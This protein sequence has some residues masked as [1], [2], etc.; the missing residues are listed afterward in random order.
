MEM[1]ALRAEFVREAQE[2]LA[3]V[4]QMILALEASLRERDAPPDTWDEIL[5]I[6]HTL[7]GN[8]GMMGYVRGETIAH[9]ME[10][11]VTIARMQPRDVAQPIVAGLFESLDALRAQVTA[12]MGGSEGPAFDGRG[13][14]SHAPPSRPAGRAK[15]D[16]A[17]WEEQFRAANAQPLADVRIAAQ[18]LDRLLELVGE[19]SAHH[20]RLGNIIG[21]LAERLPSSDTSGTEARDVIDYVAKTI[22]ELRLRVTQARLLPLS[23][24]FERTSR[25]VRDVCLRAG[26]EAELRVTGGGLVVDK[27][28]VDVLREPLLHIIRNAIDH[29]LEAPDARIAVGKPRSGTIH[30][31]AATN[32]PDLVILVRDDGR[33]IAR[34]KLAAKARERGI[35]IDGWTEDELLELVFEPTLST[36]DAVTDLSGRGIGMD[37]ARRSI[38]RFGGTVDVASI[39]GVGTAFQLRVPLVVTVHRTLVVSCGDERF[40]IPVT[41]VAATFRIHPSS[42]HTA[43]GQ[44]FTRFRD[45]MLPVDH[46][47]TRLG[48]SRVALPAGR[49]PQC[50][51]LEDGTRWRGVIVDAVVGQEDVVVKDLDP[52]CGRPSGIAGASV[53][54]DGSVVMVLD[55]RAIAGVRSGRA[56]R[57]HVRPD[58]A[59]RA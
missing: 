12:P 44:P 56:K 51:V 11:H 35:D 7:K 18:E 32:G 22:G 54:S 15:R 8:C 14:P 52:L 34:H 10:E 3:R 37:A 25:V 2:L 9:A 39:D 19:L 55:P 27:A 20:N 31:D 24:A 29:G 4:E 30:I 59:V 49:S 17:I 43:D 58:G 48:I 46:L 33:G 50:I 42:V 6:F 28:I 21:A 5:G 26:K 1:D 57:P 40:A 38:E 13:A 16:S 53:L 41:S 23:L 36:A 45:R 47:S